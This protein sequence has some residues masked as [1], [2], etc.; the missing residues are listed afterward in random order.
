[1]LGHYP[2]VHFECNLSIIKQHLHYKTW[3]FIIGVVLMR[4]DNPHCIKY[5]IIIKK[6][7]KRKRKFVKESKIQVMMEIDVDDL[8]LS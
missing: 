3:T 7:Q 4:E 6:T 2:F 8:C 1:M 5:K